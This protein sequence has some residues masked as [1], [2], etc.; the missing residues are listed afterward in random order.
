MFTGKINLVIK[1]SPVTPVTVYDVRTDAGLFI[2]FFRLSYIYTG[3][4]NRDIFAAAILVGNLKL[5]I[6]I[7]INIG[8]SEIFVNEPAGFTPF[9]NFIYL[10]ACEDKL[11]SYTNPFVTFVLA[12]LVKGT[13]AVVVSADVIVGKIATE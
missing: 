5:V 8:T 6:L 13:P 1:L 4:D 11:A 10:S 12:T 9:S 7:S 3:N 2:S